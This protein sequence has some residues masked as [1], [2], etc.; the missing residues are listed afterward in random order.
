MIGSKNLTLESSEQAATHPGQAH[1]ASPGDKRVCRRCR[2][3]APKHV[4]APYGLCRKAAVLLAPKRPPPIPCTATA[5]KYFVSLTE[6]P[7]SA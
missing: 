6:N 2:F 4:G 7:N 3:W 1:F 5:C